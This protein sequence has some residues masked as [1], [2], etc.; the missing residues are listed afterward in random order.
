MVAG[1]LI[2]EVSGE[3]WEQYV[4]RH[5]LAPLGMNHSHRVELQMQASPD[6]GYPHARAD[7]PIVGW[8]RKSRSTKRPR[9]RPTRRRRGPRD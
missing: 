6:R 9:S 5:V 7:G 1:Q 3:T 4:R 8:G 2:E